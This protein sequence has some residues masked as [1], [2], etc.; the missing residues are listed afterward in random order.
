M[1]IAQCFGQWPGSDAGVF[2]KEKDRLLCVHINEN[3]D[4]TL[5]SF[6]VLLLGESC[7]FAVVL[8]WEAVSLSWRRQ[9]C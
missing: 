1:K 8:L 4:L 9:R 3:G 2:C 7:F 6:R 5:L